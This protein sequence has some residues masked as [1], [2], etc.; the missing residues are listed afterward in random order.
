M[1]E[2]KIFSTRV[3]D[4]RIKDLKHLAVDTDKSLGE[5]LEEAIED[6]VKKYE[7]KIKK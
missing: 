7:K 5:L 2:K 6:I 4:D 3:D 1:G